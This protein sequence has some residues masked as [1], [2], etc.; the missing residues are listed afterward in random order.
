MKNSLKNLLLIALAFGLGFGLPT[1]AANQTPVDRHVRS[2]ER[3][4]ANEIKMYSLALTDATVSNVNLSADLKSATVK[5]VG[6]D[7]L[8]NVS[9]YDSVGTSHNVGDLITTGTDKRILRAFDGES[10]LL[11]QEYE[12]THVYARI[13]DSSG[14][15]TCY[16]YP[17]GGISQ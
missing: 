17:G 12:F 13:A 9:Y 2:V 7:V 16:F 1:I 14:S 8:L 4:V 3:T 11:I 10:F 15:A 5:C 6:E